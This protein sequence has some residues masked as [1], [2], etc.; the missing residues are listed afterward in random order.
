MCGASYGMSR[1]IQFLVGDRVKLKSSN[2]SQDGVLATIIAPLAMREVKGEKLM[3]YVVNLDKPRNGESQWPVK[4]ELITFVE[5]P[6]CTENGDIL[7]ELEMD[8]EMLIKN[9]KAC[10]P[11]SNFLKGILHKILGKSA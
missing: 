7:L 1:P 10:E 2:P 5:R 8:G 3:R 11:K 9:G 4:P 6:I